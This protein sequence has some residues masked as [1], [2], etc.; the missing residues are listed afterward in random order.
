M[1]DDSKVAKDDAKGLVPAAPRILARQLARLLTIDEIDHI[2]GGMISRG[3]I[4]GVTVSTRADTCTCTGCPT[5]D[6]DA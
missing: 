6:S 5:N 2:A 1:I 3:V 4:G